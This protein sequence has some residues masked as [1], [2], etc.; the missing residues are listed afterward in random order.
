MV[1]YSNGRK[2]IVNIVLANQWQLQPVSLRLVVQPKL[3]ARQA[4]R[5]NLARAVSRGGFNPKRQHFAGKHPPELAN[6]PIIIVQNSHA[7][8]GQAVDQLALG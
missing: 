1:G 8:C 7:V 2:D 6:P 4:Q 3:L 5:A